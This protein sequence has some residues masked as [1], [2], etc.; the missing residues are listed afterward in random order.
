MT[1]NFRAN[2]ANV[3]LSSILF[4]ILTTAL[5][6]N[7]SGALAYLEIQI[8]SFAYVPELRF[9]IYFL[10]S[11]YLFSGS[12]RNPMLFLIICLP[13]ILIDA[14]ALINGG[15]TIPV[16]FPFQTIYPL[17]GTL[18]AYLILKSYKLGIMML[19]CCVAFFIGA[20]TYI[21]PN[22][23]WYMHKKNQSEHLNKMELLKDTFITID[24][25][26]ICI[27]DTVMSEVI[28]TEFYFEGCS[29][30]VEKLQSLVHVSK[31]FNSSDLGLVLICD[32]SITSFKI[33][34]QAAKRLVST[35]F[36]FLYDDK[37]LCQRYG[38]RGY[39][40]ELLIYKGKIA[41]ADTG[42]GKDISMLWQ[43]SEI[44]KIKKLL[45]HEN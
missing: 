1:G 38:I 39:P 23:L 11:T 25:K 14:T 30:C 17:L 43:R 29:P 19:A 24:H 28:L 40:T 37:R 9:C 18:A 44:T 42:F 8:D 12:N 15:K 7:L 10:Y 32:G 16:R 13:F 2:S 33:F 41:G 20:K 34:Q 22:L 21:T 6:Y 36:T 35:G 4:A 5:V 31:K 27:K 3:I 45:N 26:N